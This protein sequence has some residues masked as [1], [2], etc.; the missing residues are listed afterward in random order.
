MNHP[1]ISICIPAYKRA[2]LLKKL[3]DSILNQDFRD[4]E[5]L[6]NDNSPDNAVKDLVSAYSGILPVS[7]EKNEPAISATDNCNRVM[8]RA[9]ATWIKIIH[10][11]DW[12]ARTDALGLFADAALQSGKDFIFCASNLV[13]LETNK[14]EKE[15]LTGERKKIL[16]DSVFSLF[17][18]NIIGHPSVVMHK[19]DISIEFDP[20]FNWVLDID[21]YIRYINAHKGYHYIPER[22]VNIGKGSG[23][24]SFKYYKNPKVEIPE[25]FSLLTRYAS[26]LPL[27]NE[28]VFHMVWNM[29][30]RYRIKNIGQVRTTG[31]QGRLP[32]KL[33]EIISYQKN[34]PSLILKQTPWSKILMKRCFKKITQGLYK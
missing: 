18:L 1:F 25:Y 26:D 2:D 11:D 13:Y 17:Y 28:Y 14:T 31:Y 6:I 8:K 4:Y 34:I 29:L 7:Y 24:E 27:K 16:D 19:K 23:Q 10:D 15:E 32:D 22:L 33:Q 12:F 20:A 21:Y 9:R 5:V 3:L 30:K